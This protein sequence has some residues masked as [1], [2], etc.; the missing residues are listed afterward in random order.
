[1]LSLRHKALLSISPGKELTDTQKRVIENMLPELRSNRDNLQKDMNL[2]KAEYMN[3]KNK[4]YS[5]LLCSKLDNYVEECIKLLVIKYNFL[6]EMRNVLCSYREWTDNFVEMD[7]YIS[8]VLASPV[9]GM[10]V[11]ELDKL[12]MG[13]LSSDYEIELVNPTQHEQNM[14]RIIREYFDD[15][16]EINNKLTNKTNMV[17]MKEWAKMMRTAAQKEDTARKEHLQYL[18]CID[19][20]LTLTDGDIDDDVQIMEL[21]TLVQNLLL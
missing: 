5:A 19:K 7:C 3:Y 8:K 13:I 4:Y 1:M 16:I 18:S 10:K 21:F 11:E 12:I 20:V 14:Y 2:Y 6:V 9:P 17:E 15:C